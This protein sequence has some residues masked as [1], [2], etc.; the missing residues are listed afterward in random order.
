MDVINEKQNLEF[1]IK[2]K[3]CRFQLATLQNVKVAL[4]QN[5]RFD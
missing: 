5:G 4:F 3:A 1:A 2:T